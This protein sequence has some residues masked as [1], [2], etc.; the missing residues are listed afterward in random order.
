MRRTKANSAAATVQSLIDFLIHLGWFGSGFMS[1]AQEAV[2]NYALYRNQQDG[3]DGKSYKVAEEKK[4]KK[5]IHTTRIEVLLGI[6]PP[7]NPCLVPNTRP[8]R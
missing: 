1:K 6:L 4:K 7:K 3:E 8:P 2:E 5:K